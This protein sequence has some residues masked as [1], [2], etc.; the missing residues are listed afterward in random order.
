MTI[1]ATLPDR[2]LLA[3]YAS[4]VAALTLGQSTRILELPPLEQEILKRM[5]G[6][7]RE[8]QSNEAL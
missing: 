4:I 6:V 5:G 7:K 2:E 1:P 3:A 8:L